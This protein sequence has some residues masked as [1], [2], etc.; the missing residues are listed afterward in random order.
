MDLFF[1]LP[2]VF[3]LL[4][5]SLWYWLSVRW[6]RMD[7]VDAAWGIGFIGITFLCIGIIGEISFRQAVLMTL[8]FVWGVRLTTHIVMRL[9]RGGEDPRY[10]ELRKIWGKTLPLRSYLQVFLL[11]GALL[12]VIAL[13]IILSFRNDIGFPWNVVDTVGVLL[14]LLGFVFEAVGDAQ[15]RAFVNNPRNKG[16]IMNQ[17]LWKYSRHPNYFGEVCMWWGIGLIACSVPFGYLGLLGPATLT[18]LILFVSGVPITEKRYENDEA[19]V[20]YK[21]KTNRLLPWKPRA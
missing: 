7:I 16:K 12:Y 5:M 8:V 17:G 10:K 15:L 13:P 19:Y 18:Y 11:Q 3:L 14:W 4:T 21:M 1:L 20:A 6:K 2:A 9:R